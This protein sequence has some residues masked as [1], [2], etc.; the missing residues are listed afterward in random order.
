M[1]TTINKKVLIA[2]DYD[3]SANKVAETGILLA[4][5]LGAK[6]ILCHV[7]SYPLKYSLNE[8]IRIKGFT[9]NDE[10]ELFQPDSINELKKVAK[11]YLDK[12]IGHFGDKTINTIVKDGN[13]ADSI[14]EITNNFNVS[15]IVLGSLSRKRKDNIGTGSIVDKLL[16]VTPVPL[17]IIPTKNTINP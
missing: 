12:I 11:S 10:K 7:I 2:I 3:P 4:K 6:V 16:R 5:S 14:I 17:F 15:I 8:H 9:V 1:N 13:I